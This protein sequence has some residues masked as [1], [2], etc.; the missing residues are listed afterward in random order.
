MNPKVYIPNSLRVT[1]ATDFQKRC[2]Y[3]QSPQDLIGSLFEIDHIIPVSKGGDTTRDNLC[4]CCL[5]CNR[6]KHN[7][8]NAKDPLTLKSVLLFH[9]RRQKWTRHFTWN[10]KL[11]HIIARTRSGRATIEAMKLNNDIIVPMRQ[12]WV[13][14]GRHP[15]IQT[16]DSS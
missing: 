12:I 3:C 6:Y 2:A 8:T 5:L 9:P 14:I 4:W 10:E 15:A 7:Q 1:I 13:T 11:T 16:S